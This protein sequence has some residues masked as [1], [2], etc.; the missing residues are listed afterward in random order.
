MLASLLLA[1]CVSVYA[2][3][4]KPLLKRVSVS[5]FAGQ[6]TALIGHNGAGKTTLLRTVA[7]LLTCIS[8]LLFLD[9]FLY[10]GNQWH[11]CLCAKEHSK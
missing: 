2:D 1:D 4:K 11:I 5:F 9:I 8:G 6:V 3:A 10:K 7:G